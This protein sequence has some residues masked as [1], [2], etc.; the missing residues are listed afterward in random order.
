MNAD[1]V[2][3]NANP[4]VHH[5]QEKRKQGGRKPLGW[6]QIQRL[7]FVEEEDDDV[8][9][10]ARTLDWSVERS[11]EDRA[12]FLALA[13]TA[14]AKSTN[15]S[16]LRKAGLMI[17]SSTG[18]ALRAPNFVPGRPV[19]GRQLHE[20]SSKRDKIDEEEVFEI[21]R[22]IQDPEHPLTLEQLNV[23][24]R[25]HIEVHDNYVE[26]DASRTGQTVPLSTVDV[27]FT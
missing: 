19:E 25:S 18:N 16:L 11:A 10:L 5:V 4:V 23:V 1:T 9:P 24:N 8:L 3:E 27:R 2:K 6:S 13:D 14:A 21:I 26:S 20:G 22:N 15:V 7:N 17:P 12:I